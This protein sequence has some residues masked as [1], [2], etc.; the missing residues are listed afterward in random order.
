MPIAPHPALVEEWR[1]LQ[2]NHEQYERGALL[3]K[4]AALLAFACGYVLALPYEL[5]GGLVL[6][7]WVQESIYRTSQARLGSR[8]VLLEQLIHSDAPGA[9]ACQLH[10]EWLAGRAGTAGL[11]AEYASQALRPTVAFPYGVL[12]I[13]ELIGYLG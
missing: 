1:T 10:T 4:L 2:N 5:A 9:D 7:V 6:L 12:L 3:L 11:L 8:L 13:V